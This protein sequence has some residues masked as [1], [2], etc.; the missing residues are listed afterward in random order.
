[1]SALRTFA[2]RALQGVA[3][4]AG[5]LFAYASTGNDGTGMEPLVELGKLRELEEIPPVEQ[6]RDICSVEWPT[7]VAGSETPAVQRRLCRSLGK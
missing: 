4:V 1:M 3:V 2:V 6:L 7:A 5:L